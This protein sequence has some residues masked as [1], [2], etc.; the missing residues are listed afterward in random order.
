M[1][2]VAVLYLL[3]IPVPLVWGLLA[4]VTNYIPNVGFVLGLGPP[5]LVA[6]LQGGIEQLVLVVIAYS[7]IN[8]VIQ[9]L[10]QPK[11]AGD[12][13]ACP[14]RRPS[15]PWSFG[16]SSSGHLGGYSRFP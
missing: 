14:P 15:C 7:T 9:S 5:A 2:D 16:P 4:F 11:V 1:A 3:A 12:A 6:L 13:S 8:I 10:I